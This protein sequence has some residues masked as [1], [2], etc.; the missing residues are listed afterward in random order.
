[1]ARGLSVEEAW[2]L[3]RMT[4]DDA[5]RGPGG[6]P[7]H[8]GPTVHLRISDD[9]RDR[10]DALRGDV[11]VADF[12]RSLIDDALKARERRAYIDRRKA[13]ENA[14]STKATDIEENS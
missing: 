7:R 8:V 6:R 3:V 13:K 9:T 12:L 2:G 1:M 11:K 5:P 10:V 4:E 14:R